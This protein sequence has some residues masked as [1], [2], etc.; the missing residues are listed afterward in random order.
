MQRRK[1]EPKLS[2][3]GSCNVSCAKSLLTYV[4]N[5]FIF[6]DMLTVNNVGNV[7]SHQGGT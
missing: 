7:G 4:D 6:N 3:E 5:W 1:D 2:D